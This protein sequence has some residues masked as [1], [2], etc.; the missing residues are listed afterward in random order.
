MREESVFKVVEANQ[1]NPLCLVSLPIH[2]HPSHLDLF[3]YLSPKAL[4]HLL[5]N[6]INSIVYA[7]LI[8]IIDYAN[9]IGLAFKTDCL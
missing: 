2:S 5:F 8:K 4:F 3:G 9:Q 1:K 6:V 7:L